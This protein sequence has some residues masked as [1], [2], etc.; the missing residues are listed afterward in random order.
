LKDQQWQLTQQQLQQAQSSAS[1]AQSKASAAETAADNQKTTLTEFSNGVADVN[2]KSASFMQEQRKRVSTLEAAIG[3]FRFN[4][5]IRVRDDSIFQSCPACLDRNRA[6][7]RV[8][9]GME[10]KLNED[11]TGGF[12][13]ATGWLADSNSTN[14]TLTNFFNRKTI[15]V[16]RGYITYQPFPN[17]PRTTRKSTGPSPG[18]KS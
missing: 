11:F 3:R 4:G 7:L 2:T 5:N 13:L 14:E 16:D 9:F 17:A 6:R 12:Y 18:A 8:R 10:G 15:G 1:D